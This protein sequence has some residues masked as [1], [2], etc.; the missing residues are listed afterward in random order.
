MREHKN[1]LKKTRKIM[2]KA[3]LEGRG[4]EHHH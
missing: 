1:R 3:G 4:V 2:R